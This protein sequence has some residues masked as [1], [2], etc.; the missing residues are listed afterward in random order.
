MQT[1]NT[2][3]HT[4][5]TITDKIAEWGITIAGVAVIAAMLA[6]LVLIVSEAAPLFFPPTHKHAGE[7]ALPDTTTIDDIVALGVDADLHGHIRA[8]GIILR[9]GRAGFSFLKNR[10]ILP[11]DFSALPKAPENA[12]ILSAQSDNHGMFSIFWNNGTAALYKMNSEFTLDTEGKTVVK[13]AFTPVFESRFDAEFGIPVAT[14]LRGD[15]KQHRAVSV[16][17]NGMILENSMTP[18][19]G[20]L[21]KKKST[22]H[23]RVQYVRQG[24]KITSAALNDD[25]ILYLGTEQGNIVSVD[26][27]VKPAEDV[28]VDIT[29]VYRDRRSVTSL[30]FLNGG[31]ALA[32]GGADGD[33]SVWFPKREGGAFRLR[34]SVE[35]EGTGRTISSIAASGRDRS[36]LA[37]DTSG[38]IRWLYSTTGKQLLA[39]PPTPSRTI[40]MAVN[41]RTDTLARLNDNGDITFSTLN[42]S[43]PEAGVSGFFQR[44][45][46]EGYSEA[47]FIWQSTGADTSESKLSLVPLIWG[48]IKAALYAMA[49]ATPVALAAAMYLSQFAAPVWRARLKPAV[50]MLAAVP[51]VVIGFL[52]ALWFA[53]LLEQHLQFFT[54]HF[55]YDQRNALVIAVA[56]GFAVIPTIFSLAEDAISAVP[57]ALSAASLALGASKWQTVM[58]VV[59]PTASPGI[60]TAVMLGL[61]RAV[62]ETMIVLMAAGNTPILSLS[63][64]NGMRT[65]SANI[66]VEMPEAPVGGTLYRTLFLC[67]LILFVLTLAINTAAEICRHKLRN[68]YGKV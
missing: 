9:D 50:E 13:C 1:F 49:F 41:E 60:F 38:A 45:L 30:A 29:P 37:L 19:K 7:I 52:A 24:G 3:T 66:A 2:R 25:G 61:G 46:Y 39:I 65:L 56:M 36:F 26:L 14:L 54:K 57:P 21:G 5:N 12:S 51:S 20:M 23:Q 43:Y 15:E 58:R 53:P 11:F 67:S 17:A 63:P 44:L 18:G 47:A 22:A 32:V 33:M 10:E 48:S 64:F 4:V 42:S 8:A 59:L 68:R 28:I 40:L 55:P 6:M 35:W 34:R 16:Y 31:Y 62:G 27:S